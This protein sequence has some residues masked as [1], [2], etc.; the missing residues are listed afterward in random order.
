M[1]ESSGTTVKDAH[2]EG[3][4]SCKQAENQEGNHAFFLTAVNF[5]IFQEIFVLFVCLLFSF[6]AIVGTEMD[7]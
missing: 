3:W 1:G 4:E 7:F 2:T 6:I 5:K